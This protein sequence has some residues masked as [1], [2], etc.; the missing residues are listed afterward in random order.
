M[1]GSQA[2]A[3]TLE[4]EHDLFAAGYQLV[5]GV[6]EVGRGSLAGVLSVGVAV[7]GAQAQLQVAGLIDSKA[8]SPARREKMVPEIRRWCLN[9]VGHVSP[10]EI[11]ELGMTLSLRLAA[12]RALARL[13]REGTTP[14]V[15]LLD[16]KHDWLS[17]PAPDLF[18]HQDPAHQRYEELLQQA[19]G[20]R[21]TP[22][23]G[24]VHT[25]IKGDYRCA[26]IAAAS[27]LAKVERDGL[28]H[29]LAARYPEYGWE[30]NKGYG[31]AAHRAAI[32][33]H[34]PSPLHRLTWALPADEQQVRMAYQRRHAEN[35]VNENER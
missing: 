30:N 20:H 15:V 8:L 35:G 7:I 6:D 16:G 17:A 12:Q 14:E 4:H 25:I 26:S 31:S 11:D 22:W 2:P 33:E 3:A 34:G 1:T 29:D 19:W 5:A 9:A 27:V 23:Q 10:E 24:P 28:M 18:G 32:S 21:N 13:G